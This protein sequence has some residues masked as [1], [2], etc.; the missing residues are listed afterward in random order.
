MP[1]GRVASC[2]APSDFSRPPLLPRPR[3]LPLA[4]HA[5]G[6][7]RLLR[8]YVCPFHLPDKMAFVVAQR[9]STP[10]IDASWRATRQTLAPADNANLGRFVDVT[11]SAD[12]YARRTIR[13]RSSPIVL[14]ARWFTPHF[15]DALLKNHGRHCG[16]LFKDLHT[17][18]W[19]AQ[20]PARP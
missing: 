16:L 17:E 20:P 1:S 13:R 4:F 5:S 6:V 15:R 19:F 11:A 9:V 8:Q 12:A 3:Q 14:W 18:L 2:Q 10:P 7:L